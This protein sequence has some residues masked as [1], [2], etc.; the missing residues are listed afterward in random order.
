M[1]RDEASIDVASH[2]ETSR[3]EASQEEASVD[4]AN[5]DVDE[6]SHGQVVVQTTLVRIQIR[7]FKRS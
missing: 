5:L 2:D 4:M 7:L 3:D 6:A 1:S